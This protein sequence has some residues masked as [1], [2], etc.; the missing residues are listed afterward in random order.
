MHSLNI[1]S[2]ILWDSYNCSTLIEPLIAVPCCSTV[3]NRYTAWSFY[4][5]EGI[6]GKS[7]VV[8]EFTFFSYAIPFPFFP[9][10][11]PPYLN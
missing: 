11:P 4:P 5:G 2:T 7:D 8:T 1:M 10:L 6:D 3:I 9:F